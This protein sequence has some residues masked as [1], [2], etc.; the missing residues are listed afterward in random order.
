M[1]LVQEMMAAHRLVGGIVYDAVMAGDWSIMSQFQPEHCAPIFPVPERIVAYH[2]VRRGDLTVCLPGAEPIRA[3]AG[4]MVLFPRNDP[5]IICSSPDVPPTAAEQVFTSDGK[6]GPNVVRISGDGPECALYCGW[7]G[8]DDSDEALIS[9]LPAVL[10]ARS[11]GQA[12]G[13][14]LSSSLRYAAEE[15]SGNAVM[16][17]RL[18]QLFFEE[19]V[20]RY[21]ETLPPEEEQ[22]LAA[23]R[24]PAIA[25]ALALI[26]DDQ[27]PAV[28]L[29]MLAREAGLSRTVLMERFVALLGAPPMRYR[30]RWK[31]RRAARL[32]GDGEPIADV[33]FAV[34]F[35][36]EAAFTRAFKRAYGEPPATWR[37]KA[38]SGAG[39]T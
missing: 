26:Q 5:H 16:V 19:A 39:A 18:S 24:D 15:L 2:Y 38:T 28:T 4:T 7:L 37:S 22:R 8:V 32:L 36:S 31:L 3:S 9:A 11:D 6:Q 10:T 17:A 27:L 33:A 23:L 12:R 34:G 14:F 29:D 30:A 21:L 13:A 25:R 35:S 20:S 1:N